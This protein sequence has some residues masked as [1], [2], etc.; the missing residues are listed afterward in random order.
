MAGAR[1]SEREVKTEGILFMNM[2]A[3]RAEADVQRDPNRN[4]SDVT[5]MYVRTRVTYV[6]LIARIN[7]RAARHTNGSLFLFSP[8][9]FSLF[10]PEIRAFPPLLP[11]P[12][13]FPLLLLTRLINNRPHADGHFG[14][15]ESLRA[16]F[17]N[18]YIARISLAASRESTS[19]SSPRQK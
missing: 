15:T 11:L 2:H 12:T 16:F 8:V 9:F 5:E 19:S 6:S 14:L 1:G 4:R 3:R 10:F 18:P 17:A 13:A 7:V